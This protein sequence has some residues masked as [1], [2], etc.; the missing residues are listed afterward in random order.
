MPLDVYP[1]SSMLKAITW[2]QVYVVCH[3][4]L[5]FF[6]NPNIFIHLHPCF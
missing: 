1:C 2:P 4:S 6:T 3:A 5:I